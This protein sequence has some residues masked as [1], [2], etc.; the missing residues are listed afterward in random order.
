MRNTLLWAILVALAVLAKP[1]D[2]GAEAVGDAADHALALPEMDD[3]LLLRRAPRMDTAPIGVPSSQLPVFLRA[4]ALDGALNGEIM[5]HGTA[6][7]R[8]RGISITADQLRYLVPDERCI[9]DG[10][11]VVTRGLDVVTGPNAT[12]NLGDQSGTVA[13]PN[14]EIG[15]GPGRARSARASAAEITFID[16]D[17]QH[18]EQASY[19]TCTVGDDAWFL[20]GNSVDLDDAGQIGVARGARIVFEGMPLLYSPYMSF[21][22]NDQRKSGFLAPTIGTTATSG[23]DIALP[24]YFN[25]APNF[26]DTATARVMTKRG[27]QLADE[28]RYLQPDYRGMFEGELLNHDA[29]A[30]GRRYEFSLNHTQELPFGIHLDAKAQ[31]V[32]D[33][34]YFRDLSTLITATSTNYLQRSLTL[35]TGVNGWSLMGQTMDYQTVQDPNA[36][37]PD[38]YRMLPQMVAN[39]SKRWNGL[40]LSMQNEFVDFHQSAGQYTPTYDVN[41][42]RLISYPSVAV[43]LSRDWGYITPKVGLHLT[44]YLTSPLFPGQQ[45]QRLTR[46]VPI[47]SV[48]AGLFFER[49]LN[50]AGKDLVQT[51][52]PRLYFLSIPYRRQDGLPVFNTGVADVNYSQ[53]FSE[54]AYNGPDRINDARQLTVGMQTRLLDPATGTESMRAVL[55]QRFYYR[56]Q[57]VVLP[58][59][60]EI[61]RVDNVSDVIAG[62]T[63]RVSTTLRG[64][65]STDYNPS[66][67]RTEKFVL[68]GH[69]EP[70]PGRTLNLGYYIDRDTIGQPDIRQID[71]SGEWPAGGRWTALGRLDY[72][73]AQSILVDGLLGAEYTAGCWALRIVTYRYAVS[74]TQT[75]SALF[76]QLE[77][78]GLARLGTNPL[79]ALR[80]NIPGYRK[81]NELSQPTTFLP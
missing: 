15:A 5:A 31:E 6:E 42:K 78:N 79:E 61:P 38:Q 48:D 11:V 46:A 26:D 28:F 54:N 20:T 52:E 77:L 34:N 19:T 37:V 67:K 14:I 55:G 1:G 59:G 2:A 80:M 32:S 66:L 68:A 69:Y 65:L 25:I 45:S 9:A 70:Q 30:G 18:L 56:A 4:D 21:P 36:P 51:L 76:L 23:V 13:E 72:D 49:E 50:L 39:Y 60:A 17:H 12:Y 57:S 47:S 41:G 43:P 3:P 62:L 53:L 74:S 58:F 44:E 71:I 7:V 10:H 35:S 16:Q 75:A 24:Y 40:A 8:Q 63:G 33:S 73:T 27:I 81:T 22:L 64:E 29:F